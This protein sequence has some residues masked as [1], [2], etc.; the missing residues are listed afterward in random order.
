MRLLMLFALVLVAAC[1][2]REGTFRGL[3]ASA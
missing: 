2:I 3:S 1:T